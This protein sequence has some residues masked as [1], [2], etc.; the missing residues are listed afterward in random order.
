MSSVKYQKE[1]QS[2]NPYLKPIFS[3]DLDRESSMLFY[4]FD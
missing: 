4:E 3:V 2:N 1:I